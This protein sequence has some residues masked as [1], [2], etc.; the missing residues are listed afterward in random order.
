MT[1]Q[2]VKIG[3]IQNISSTTEEENTPFVFDC[4]HVIVEAETGA[5]K[6]TGPVSSYLDNAIERNRALMAYDF[7]GKEHFSIK[8]L[9]A[10]HGRIDDVVEFGKPGGVNINLLSGMN[11]KQ[12]ESFARQLIPGSREPFWKEG[13]VVMYTSIFE[14][15]YT[16]KKLYRFTLEEMGLPY[17][18]LRMAGTIED[19]KK[20]RVAFDDEKKDRYVD[21]SVGSEPLTFRELN[22][23]VLDVLK[24]V[25]LI[26]NGKYLYFDKIERRIAQHLKSG[27]RRPDL[28]TVRK[29]DAML[30]DVK[31]K[32][33]A[34]A[35]FEPNLDV[36]ESSGNNGLLM[37]LR[38][39]LSTLSD[40]PFINDPNGHGLESLLRQRKIVIVNTESFTD[41]VNGLVLSN[42]L[43]EISFRTRLRQSARIETSIVI[44]EASRVLNG[45]DLY[46]D[47][48]REAGCE[49]MISIQNQRQ[50]ILKFGE[51]E[52]ESIAG[53]F[54]HRFEVL[55]RDESTGEVL[56]N[57][58][59]EETE[60]R[61]KPYYFNEAD[62]ERMEYEFQKSRGH[63]SAEIGGEEAFIVYDHMLWENSQ[64]MIKRYLD[65]REELVDG[66][67]PAA[68]AGEMEMLVNR[69][70][71]ERYIDVGPLMEKV[72]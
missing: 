9:A 56:M 42:T 14:A 25:A 36:S 26:Q 16:L 30:L 55:G 57:V 59:G 46:N 62:L 4:K 54:V 12:F 60:H 15:L 33:Q 24:L 20:S 52:W 7:K 8:Y 47:V 6:T 70:E 21:Y 67:V 10:R 2:T 50:M 43:R 40:N 3:F 72:S 18:E 65:G 31:K 38:S 49:L 58:I 35:P 44:D 11:R 13:A 71:N 29:V 68:E 45:D 63:Y 37:T 28:L 69:M 48:L 22:S 34:L 53:N 19:N 51:T 64:Q 61:L 39:A 66:F 1:K 32:I 23:Y 41:A 17:Y 5:G 27:R